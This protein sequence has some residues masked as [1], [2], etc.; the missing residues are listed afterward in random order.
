MAEFAYTTVP[1][2]IAPL[3]QKI[4][5]VGIPPKVS[6]QW[7]KTI[8]FTSSN[9]TTLVSVL[10]QIGFVDSSGVPGATWSQFR[11]AKHK[12]VL[13]GAIRSGYAELFAV[14]PDA[15]QR[16]PTELE[17]VFSTSS[18]AGKQV[19]AKTVSTFK[20]LSESATFSPDGIGSDPRLSAESIHEPVQ[21]HP[22]TKHQLGGTAAPSVH[23]DIQV[24]IAPESSP[25]QIEQ[26][27]KSMAKHLYG[28]GDA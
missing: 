19:I 9:D 1:G 22:V 13:G 16:T 5:E 26:I 10:K 25:E 21:V 24:H 12:E 14:Y 6:V 3:L 20:A 15:D 11:G 23:I 18:A 2:K 8:G 4:R 7:L 17:H 28:K 27:F